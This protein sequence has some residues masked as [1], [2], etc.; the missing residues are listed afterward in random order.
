MAK[1]RVIKQ[2]TEEQRRRIM[3]TPGVIV[4]RRKGP[5]KESLSTSRLRV[6]V[7]ISAAELIDDDEDE[8][9]AP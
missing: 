5:P 4:H 8:S 2:M 6:L 9:H 7:P 3:E 1:D